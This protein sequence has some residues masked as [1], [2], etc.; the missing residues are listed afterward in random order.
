[1]Y[2]KA[3]WLVN[4]K[5]LNIDIIN[6]IIEEDD[7]KYIC[8]QGPYSNDGLIITPLNGNRELKVKPKSYQTIDLLFV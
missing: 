3:A 7:Y 1:M 2:P 6:N 8:K 4:N 5:S